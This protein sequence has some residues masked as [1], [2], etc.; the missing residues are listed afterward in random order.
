MNK[1]ELIDAMA[2][3]AGITKAQAKSALD[4]FPFNCFLNEYRVVA[5]FTG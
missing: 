3:D 2:S 5:V 4:S 1:S